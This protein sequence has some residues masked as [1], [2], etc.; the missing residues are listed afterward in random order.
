[1]TNLTKIGKGA[2]SFFIGYIFIIVMNYLFP[3]LIETLQTIYPS[4]EFEQIGILGLMV[5]YVILCIITPQYYILTGLREQSTTQQGAITIFLAILIFFFGIILTYKAYY[6]I[7]ILA[8]LADNGITQAIFW[9]G[10]IGVWTEIILIT[11]AYMILEGIRK[12]Q[13]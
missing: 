11:P 13:A 8:S 7:P 3:P 2:F 5:V 4:A 6:M 9:I 1:M 10:T 12:E